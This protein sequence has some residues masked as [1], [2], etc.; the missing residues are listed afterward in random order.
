MDVAYEYFQR[1]MEFR[2]FHEND[3]TPTLIK[4]IAMSQNFLSTDP[5]Y[6]VFALLGVSSDGAD[7]IATPNY[8][9]SGDVIFRN[10][11]RSLIQRTNSLDLL[12][13][14]NTSGVPA[15]PASL[16]SWLSE[17]RNPT[18]PEEAHALAK[19]RG[20]KLILPRRHL[21][22]TRTS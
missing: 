12:L 9:Q 10:M 14:S 13:I 3:T 15:R 17:W 18:L 21:Q 20:R 5:R 16:P 19:K 6:K 1:V 11:T 4:A 22:I 7:L 8:Q 2:S